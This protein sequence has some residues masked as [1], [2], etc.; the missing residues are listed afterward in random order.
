MNQTELKIWLNGREL[1]DIHLGTHG[2][3]PF[4]SKEM[5]TIF[6]ARGPAFNK[7]VTMEPFESVNVYPL[8]AHLLGIKPRPNN[9]SLSVFAHVLKEWDTPIE[10]LDIGGEFSITVYSVLFAVGFL[11][12][13]F[14]LVAVYFILMHIYWGTCGSPRISYSKVHEAF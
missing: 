12:S 14:V 10:S 4:A 1:S 2:Y 8:L 5:H 9:G 3:D 13:M 11:L 7:N 6:F